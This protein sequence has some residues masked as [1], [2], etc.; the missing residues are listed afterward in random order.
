MEKVDIFISWHGQRGNAVASALKGWL[1][2]IVNAFNPWFSSS[3]DKG[4]RWRTEIANRLAQAKAG[5]IV[6]TPSA[7]SSPWLLFESGAIAKS[8]DKT[9]ACTLLV[10]LKNEEVTE[11]LAQFQ[12]TAA[13]KDEILKL[14][15]TLNT[16][17]ESGERM[18]DEHVQRAFEKWW[19]DLEKT[20]RNLPDD[21]PANK[22]QRELSDMLAEL[23]AVSRETSRGVAE[24][25]HDLLIGFDDVGRIQS[26]MLNRLFPPSTLERVLSG[27]GS[28][29]NLGLLGG[30]QAKQSASITAKV[31]PPKTDTG[32]E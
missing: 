26:Y 2:Q 8:P 9:Y 16:V 19:P 28:T 5:I 30:V 1:P 29:V 11:P 20:L 24:S 18:P 6:L 32:Q 31:E 3:T 10:G 15:K 4:M 22:P 17:L 13:T 27:E 12:H 7:L 21:E 23:V 25:H 14:V